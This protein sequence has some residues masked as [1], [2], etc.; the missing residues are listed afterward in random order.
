MF[1]LESN[2][3]ATMSRRLEFAVNSKSIFI[4]RGDTACEIRSTVTGC[5]YNKWKDAM[6]LFPE[7]ST[8][9]KIEQVLHRGII[10]AIEKLSERLMWLF[11]TD[12]QRTHSL[13][14][15]WG[16]SEGAM[17]AV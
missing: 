1:P 17:S 3:E 6:C 11:R 7:P 16:H 12:K 10:S 14:F 9:E 13:W 15:L 8:G 4:T 2:Q 5:V